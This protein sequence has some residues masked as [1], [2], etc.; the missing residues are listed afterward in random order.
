MPRF[1]VRR[2]RN[3]PATEAVR[4]L[5]RRHKMPLPDGRVS[6]AQRGV[7]RAATLKQAARVLYDK[8]RATATTGTPAR[9]DEAHHDRVIRLDV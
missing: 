1:M 4:G 3:D 9:R 5:V 7:Y 2:R 6:S 8:T